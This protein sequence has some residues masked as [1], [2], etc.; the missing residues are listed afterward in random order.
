MPG[1][2]AEY[3]P[4]TLPSP[5]ALPRLLPLSVGGDGSVKW[6]YPLLGVNT[7]SCLVIRGCAEP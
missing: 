4:P 7:E 2:W 3:W 5:P 6:A 1:C